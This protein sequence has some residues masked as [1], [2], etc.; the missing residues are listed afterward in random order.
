M[1]TSTRFAS[2]ASSTVPSIQAS[3]TPHGTVRRRASPP[4]TRRFALARRVAAALL[5]LGAFVAVASDAHAQA[6][7]IGPYY[8][9]TSDLGFHVKRPAD[10]DLI[11][12]QPGEANV[13]AKFDPPVNKYIELGLDS[14]GSPNY[15]YLHCW[16]VKFDRRAKPA[17]AEPEKGIKRFSTSA[18]DLAEWIKS[19]GDIQGG[20]SF[21]IDSQKDFTADK[22]SATEYQYVSP[23]DPKTSTRLHATVY[24]LSPDVEIA[25]V[26]NGPGDP[27]KW[28]KYEAV[29]TPMSRSFGVE[30]IKAVA[31]ATPQGE[32]MRDKKRAELMKSIATLPGWKLYE[33]PNYFVLTPHTDKAF[34]EELKQRLEAIHSIYEQDY[35]AAKAEEYRKA[36]ASATTGTKSDEDKAREAA[37]KEIMG[38]EGDPKEQAKCSVVRVFTDRE[39]Y[40]SYGGPGGSAG[41]W[42][43]FHKELVLYD[44]QA[45]GGR[46]D[47][48]IVLNHEAFHQYIYYF[49]GNISPHSWYNEGTGDF[50]SG[51]F[52]KNGRF[53]LQ[54]NKWRIST[55]KEN[56]AASEREKGAT[57]FCPL[58]EFVRWDQREYYG[59]NKYQLGGGE[60]YAQGWS[61]IYFLRTGKKNNAKGW[62]PAWDGILETYLR[63]LALS[64]KVEQ[65]VEEAFRGVDMAALQKSWIEYT[66]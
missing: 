44:D 6:P 26:F 43:P 3:P 19:A 62:D 18:K 15:L 31:G 45:G 23:G 24:K 13:I 38:E 60:N 49:Y 7:K 25:L 4:T 61:F 55:I 65:A 1:P 20:G 5:S 9:D 39:S 16:L 51:Y 8:K 37:M 11:P 52:W 34:V 14:G 12:P 22:I 27:K 10:W 54:P 59:Q 35:P 40:H 47:T 29:F 57:T 32:T 30:N 36:G 17:D 50:Y 41:Y 56:I 42:A 2:L 53:V 48:W 46:N 58:D 63:S 21:K 64:G 33:T 28:V 66:R